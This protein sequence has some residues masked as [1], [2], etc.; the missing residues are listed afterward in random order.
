MRI[1]A[2][3]L[4]ASDRISRGVEQDR[5]GALAAQLLAEVADAD[6]AEV[7]VVP[8]ELERIAETL[9]EWCAEGMD[10]ILTVGGT[11]FSPRD[12]TPEATR[13]VIEREAPGISTA[14]LVRGLES[15]PR[16]M[17]SRA[18]AGVCGRTLI[19]N[20]PGSRSAVTE[21]VEY[22]LEVLPHALEIIGGAPEAYTD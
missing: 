9:R 16:A 13:T 11:G 12:V 10:L 22:L 15:T 20:L 8:D 7:R 14:L 18:T 4:V 17:L 5:S 3:I 21:S 2:A 6:V 1:R 19:V